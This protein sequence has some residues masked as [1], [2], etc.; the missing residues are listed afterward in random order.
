VAQ[1]VVTNSKH[2]GES[3]RGGWCGHAT[4]LSPPA[5]MFIVVNILL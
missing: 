5:A 1:S 3:C 4:M 2:E